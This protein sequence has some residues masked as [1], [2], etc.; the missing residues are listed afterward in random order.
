MKCKN[1]VN[2]CADWCDMKA[3]SPDPELERDCHWFA[4]KT[5]ADRL[6]DMSDEKLANWLWAYADGSG[7]TPPQW[8]D[9]LKQEATDG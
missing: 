4:Q 6:R 9:W 1:C 3:D 7:K 2:L 8:L 5:N